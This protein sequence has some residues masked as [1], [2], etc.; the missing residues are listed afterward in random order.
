MAYLDDTN[1]IITDE[2]KIN[3]FNLEQKVY[4]YAKEFYKEAVPY[5]N[6][7]IGDSTRTINDDILP[8]YCYDEMTECV[9]AVQQGRSW[10]VVGRWR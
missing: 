1:Y 7:Y 10:A 2:Q 6:M 3:Y 5:F 9:R 4:A 8:L